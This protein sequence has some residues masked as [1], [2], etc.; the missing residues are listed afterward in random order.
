MTPIIGANYPRIVTPLIDSACTNLDIL[1][2]QW[3]YYSYMGKSNIQG[4]NYAVKSACARGVPTRVVIHSGGPND[5]LSKL[6]ARMAAELTS[7]GASVKFGSRGGCL[8][9]KMLLIDKTIAVVGSH[10][11]CQRSMSSNIETGVV[12][13]GSGEI[14][15]FL[16]YFDL[17]WGQN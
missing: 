9:S 14:R 16:E 5:H 6:N 13:E 1:M 15:P 17:I 7:W 12:V 10:N 8:H 4:L 11:F 3:R 2:Y